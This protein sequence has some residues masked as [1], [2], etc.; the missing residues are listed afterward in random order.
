MK[1]L[2]GKVALVTGA[3]QGIGAPIAARLADSDDRTSP[4]PTWSSGSRPALRL[5]KVDWETVSGRATRL[6]RLSVGGRPSELHQRG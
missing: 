1:K 2:E 3:A 6:F 5:P 4:I